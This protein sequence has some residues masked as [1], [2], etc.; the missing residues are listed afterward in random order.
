MAKWKDW[1]DEVKKMTPEQRTE[2]LRALHT[3]SSW[4]MFKEEFGWTGIGVIAAE[5]QVAVDE[6]ER[7]ER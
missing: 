3:L 2:R 1:H 4:P 5:I 7:L 6:A